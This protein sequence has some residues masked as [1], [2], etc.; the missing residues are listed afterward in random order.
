MIVISMTD[1]TD[2]AQVIRDYQSKSSSSEWATI[3]PFVIETATLALPYVTYRPRRVIHALS[4]LARACAGLGWSLEADT[5]LR[6]EIIDFVVASHMPNLSAGSQAVVRPIL[7]RIAEAIG[8]EGTPQRLQALTGSTPSHPYPDEALSELA[9]WART[10][11]G[12]WRCGSALALVAL[13]AG[14]GLS[15]SEIMRVRRG[16]LVSCATGTTVA[17]TGP[18]A[19]QV[20]LLARWERTLADSCGDLSDDDWLFRPGPRGHHLNL[21]TNFI[22]RSAGAEQVRPNVQRLRST[23]L[24]H[25]LS[26][27]THAAALVR[28]AGLT[29]LE[30]LNRFLPFADV[31]SAEQMDAE[32]R[33]A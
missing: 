12:Q 8:P 26:R 16:D 24:V 7:L 23:W 29:T 25:H 21:V 31:P 27:G 18:R 11:S 3:G 17:V 4:N 10:Q 15:S 5:V 6:R 22:S 1:I 28:A 13:G 30:S 32:L 20:P 14:A 19:R 33:D 2:L 9:W